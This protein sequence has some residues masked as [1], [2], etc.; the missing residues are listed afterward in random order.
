MTG[1]VS[2]TTISIPAVETPKNLK[3]GQL[4]GKSGRHSKTI[5]LRR[6]GKPLLPENKMRRFNSKNTNYS[7]HQFAHFS[8][9]GKTLKS[10]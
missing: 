4:T 5:L 2:A 1:D 6:A 3:K 10:T 7:A 8:Y 9:T